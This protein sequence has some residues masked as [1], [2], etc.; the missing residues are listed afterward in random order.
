VLLAAAALVPLLLFGAIATRGPVEPNWAALYIVGAAPLVAATVQPLARW[1][2][3]AAAVNVLLLSLYAVHAATAALPLPHGA[4]R[5]LRETHGYAALAT[6]LSGQEGPLFADRYQTAAMLNFYG[7]GTPVSQWPGLTRPSEYGLGRI[8]PIP[9]L[10][11]LRRSGFTL[12]VWKYAVPKIEGYKRVSVE[13]FFDCRGMPL[14]GVS[15]I[16]WPE[17]SPCGDDWLHVWR[18]LRYEAK[19]G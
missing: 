17:A 8:V 13:T 6:R 7:A 14:H 16:A 15:G 3:A 11:E 4:D 18:V 2:V 12:V 5:V 1:A 19:G 9:D 10:D